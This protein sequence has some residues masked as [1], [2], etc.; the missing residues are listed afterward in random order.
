MHKVNINFVLEFRI[1]SSC[2][3]FLSMFTFIIFIL[4]ILL[5]A[6]PK[7]KDEKQSRRTTLI[8]IFFDEFCP[9]CQ[10][11][12]LFITKLFCQFNYPRS[13]ESV[14]NPSIGPNSRRDELPSYMVSSIYE[15]S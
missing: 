12:V 15:Q 10:V 2:K 3:L 4:A 6:Y 7:D 11:I 9:G 8:S 13:F 5:S 14:E 1:N